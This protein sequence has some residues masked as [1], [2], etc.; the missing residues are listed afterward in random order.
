MGMEVSAVK[1]NYVVYYDSLFS[2]FDST[3]FS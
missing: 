1:I 3:F 2:Y